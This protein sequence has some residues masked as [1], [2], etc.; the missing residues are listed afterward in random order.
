MSLPAFGH[1]VAGQIRV[2]FEV[3]DVAADLTAG[4]AKLIALPTRTP[5]DSQSARPAGPAAAHSPRSGNWAEQLAAHGE[6]QGR[7]P[8]ANVVILPLSKVATAWPTR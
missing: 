5:W 6:R 2:A 1:R 3:G 7:G 8:I 4:G